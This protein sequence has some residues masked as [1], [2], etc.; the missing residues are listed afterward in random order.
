MIR[1]WVWQISC[2]EGYRRFI[3][4][5]K[6]VSQMS[7]S[8]QYTCAHLK[9]LYSFGPKAGAS[10]S[11]D[12]LTEPSNATLSH[13]LQH[14]VWTFFKSFVWSFT[15]QR[16]MHEFSVSHTHV[17]CLCSTVLPNCCFGR[18]V[19]YT[20]WQTR[21]LCVRLSGSGCLTPPAS[22]VWRQVRWGHIPT[23][24]S[25]LIPCE[26]SCCHWKPWLLYLVSR[27]KPWCLP[28]TFSCWNMHFFCSFI[29]IINIYRCL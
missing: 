4:G 18:C 26:P 8:I 15:V 14:V 5:L 24:P 13:V 21:F 29:W 12:L 7:P 28:N 16:R 17:Q 20:C 2:T 3:E 11:L 9:V 1:S 6:R 23:V 10:N 22:L 27:A 19:R 25:D